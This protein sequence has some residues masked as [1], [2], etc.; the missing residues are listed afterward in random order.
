M[1]KNNKSHSCILDRKLSLFWINNN[2]TSSLANPDEDGFKIITR[3][4][5]MAIL[6]NL[7]LLILRS[8]I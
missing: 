5:T 8:L 7:P 2:P 4:N 1:K 3:H 6:I